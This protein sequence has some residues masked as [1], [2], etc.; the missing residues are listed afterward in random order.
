MCRPLIA[1]ALIAPAFAGLSVEKISGG[2]E[3]PVWLG[4]PKGTDD[5]LW[6]IEQAGRIWTIDATTGARGEKPWLDISHDVSRAGNEEGLL[7]LAFAPD[8][9]NSGRFYVNFT[10][11]KQKTRIV[12]FTAKDGTVDPATAET[13]LEFDQPWRNHNGGWIGFGPDGYLYIGNGDGGSANDPKGA[14][15]NLQTLLGK[16]LRIDVSV[17]KGYRVPQDNPFLKTAGA[18]PEIWAWGLRN[19]WRCSFD[20]R[21]GDLWIGDVGQNK[22]EEINF[23]TQGKG[24]GANFGWRLR[25]GD[26]ATPEVG[27]E[28]PADAVEPVYVYRHGMK[29][30]EGLSV[31]GGYVHRGE[32]KSL[33]GRYIFADYQN[34]R[35]W[36]FTLQG[37]K[38][39][40]FKDHTEEL[41]PQ[42][43]R[44]NLISSFGEDN[45]GRL[46]VIDHTGPV[47]RV[48]E[49]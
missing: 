2:F 10:D 44:I 12:R 37:N 34:P 25:E 6:V 16:M 36:S 15:Q 24:A 14:G 11:K 28:K 22:T 29:S 17:E 4:Q 48:V 27:G 8:H 43:G 18:R 35:I 20:R 49:R 45:A 26:M 31:T 23:V 3:R 46:Y 7:G 19:P 33:N 5:K 42:N 13:L 32:L 9:A 41:Q 21:T 30:N 39:A 40:D 47:Y 38:A 1:A